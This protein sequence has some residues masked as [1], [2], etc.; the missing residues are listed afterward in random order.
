[1]SHNRGWLYVGSTS[2]SKQKTVFL[3]APGR[4]PTFTITDRISLEFLEIIF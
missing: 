1:M 2:A 3:V 4:L